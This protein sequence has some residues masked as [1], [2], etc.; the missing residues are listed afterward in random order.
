VLDSPL[1]TFPSLQGTFVRMLFLQP[2]CSHGIKALGFLDLCQIPPDRVFR[3]QTSCPSIK[4]G[5]EHQAMNFFPILPSICHFNTRNHI[6]KYWTWYQSI[7]SDSICYTIKRRKTHARTGLSTRS[8]AL[9]TVEHQ[10]P[11]NQ[12]PIL[13]T[14]STL[15]M[16]RKHGTT[17]QLHG[18]DAEMQPAPP[19]QNGPL[20]AFMQQRS[21]PLMNTTPIRMNATLPESCS[22]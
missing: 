17:I 12:N 21:T 3:F 22:S 7:C 5:L 8:V 20:H 2:Y 6:L 19:A 13:D 15:A 18:A 9:G 10:H 16:I 4:A 11:S 14:G 1:Y